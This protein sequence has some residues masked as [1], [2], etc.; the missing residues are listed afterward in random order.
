MYFVQLVS[1]EASN[2]NKLLF[3]LLGKLNICN[4]VAKS[5]SLRQVEDGIRI[6]EKILEKKDKILRPKDGELVAEKTG[7]DE[8]SRLLNPNWFNRM[9]N[10]NMVFRVFNLNIKRLSLPMLAW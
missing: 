9:S 6:A 10:K 8:Y 3:Y 7:E 2:L 5:D 4:S 1:G